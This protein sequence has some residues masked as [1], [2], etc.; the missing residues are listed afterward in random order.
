[1]NFLILADIQAAIQ[2]EKTARDLS[3]QLFY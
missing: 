2:G 1:L 3:W